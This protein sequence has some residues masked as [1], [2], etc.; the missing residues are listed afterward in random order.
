MFGHV[1]RYK[2]AH[3]LFW[4]D[5][6]SVVC[7]YFLC[8]FTATDSSEGSPASSVASPRSIMVHHDFGGKEAKCARKQNIDYD[9]QHLAPHYLLP[10]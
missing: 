1:S 8:S 6:W 5:L 4:A 7:S 3:V 10:R 2:N 9:R